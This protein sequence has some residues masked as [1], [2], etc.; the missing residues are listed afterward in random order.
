MSRKEYEMM[1]KLNAQLGGQF[2]SAFKSANSTLAKLQSEIQSLNKTQGDIS[3]YKK[4]QS[5][6]QQTKTKLDILQ[7]EYQ[8]L[9]EEYDQTGEG[10]TA[11][12][13]KMLKKKLAIEK[14]SAAVETHERKLNQLGDALHEAGVDTDNLT[15]ESQRL[16]EQQ[17]QLKHR[18]EEVA[19]E[20]DDSGEKAGKFGEDATGA[21]EGLKEALVSAGILQMIKAIGK[22]FIESAKESIMFESAI[23]GV[24]KTIDG[25]DEQLAA[26][27]SEIAQLATRI[28]ASTEEIAGVAEAAGQLGIAT[29]NVM[30]FSEVMI[31][32]GEATNLT[33]DE[34]ASA[35]AKFANIT[36]TA[37]EDY[38]RL[39]AV[40]VDM[41]NN[42]ATTEA[43]IVHMSTRLASAGTLA[44]LSEAEIMAL[45]TA[46]SSVGIE[47]EAGGTAMTQT[48]AAIEKAVVGGGDILDEYARISGMSAEK[49]ADAWEN[50][51]IEAIQAFIGGLGRLDE[52]GESATIVLDNLGLKGVRQSNMLKSLALASETL[53]KS[54]DVANTAWDENTALVEEAGKRYATTESKLAMV[55]NSYSNLKVAIGDVFTPVLKKLADLANKLLG[56][57]TEF[58]KNN[59]GV[60]KAI[61][62]V[63]IALGTFAG[64]LAA[65]TLVSKV[66]KAATVA[67]N[68]ALNSNPFMAIATAI[69]LVVT[70]LATYAIA[71]ADAEDASQQFTQTSQAEQRQIEELS[72][73]YDE[74]CKSYGETSEEAQLLGWKV[75][76]LTEHF[77]NNKQTIQEYIEE[78]DNF[79]SATHDMLDANMDAYEELDK[80][81]A[82]TYALVH[83]LEYL[84]NQSEITAESQAEMEAIIEAL[85]EQLPELKLNY[86]DVIS[87]MT[88]FGLTV[89]QIIKKEANR[90][91]YEKTQKFAAAALNAQTE[92]E[93]RLNEAIEQKAGSQERFNKAQAAYM[94]EYNKIPASKGYNDIDYANRV[95]GLEFSDVGKEYRAAQE[96]L[97]LYEGE[98][99]NAQAVFDEATA[100]YELYRGDLA[101][102]IGE[103]AEAGGEAEAAITATYESVEQLSVAYRDAY[104]AAYE[105]VSGQYSLWD[106][107]AEVV[108]TSASTINEG[109]ESQQTYWTD[110][111]NNLENLSARGEDIA[112]LNSM[113]AEFADGSA[114]SVNAIAGMA[115]ASDEELAE[116]VANWQKLKEEQDKVAGSLAEVRTDFSNQ[117]DLIKDDLADDISGMDLSDEAKESAKQ[118]IQGFIDGAKG[119]LPQVQQAYKEVGDTAARA[120]NGALDINSPSKVTDYS[121]QMSVKGFMLPA[122]EMKP[123]VRKAYHD[124]GE[125]GAEGISDATTNSPTP[126]LAEQSGG[127]S[128]VTMQISYT[129]TG[130]AGPELEG[131]LNESAQHLRQIVIDVMNERAVDESR[132]RY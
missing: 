51:P 23:T 54:V 15:G 124:L 44:G 36:G 117:M 24:Y 73:E 119:L 82:R 78:C 108:A 132:R 62:A 125:A 31:D 79:N 33:A 10:S 29:E 52:Q 16:S 49:F 74:A 18:Q 75:D 70:A 27:E 106:T 121:G 86:E 109:L 69:T 7:K 80:S 120:L 22:A 30:G 11:L 68:A 126:I 45:A 83:R 92:A 103:T 53:G 43:D 12:E 97:A 8:Q 1:L 48:L 14:A 72:A 58:V 105:S 95:G 26:I 111:N 9:Q 66:A 91:R 118:T 13:T 99:E 110:Y 38:G 87:G 127:A 131:Q 50:K 17:K 129:I 28:P 98:V 102:M 65:Y 20:F 89:D 37:A 21:I 6:L 39:G 40:V 67:L 25:T 63:T 55:K 96:E 60:V 84:A 100:D 116:M 5:A 3:A 112:G 34:A 47:A 76:E 90:D 107:A 104:T 115:S 61:S 2:G 42:F 123:E 35:F 113:I 19:D 93:Q 46:M 59:P 64:A 32:L 122:E 85:N 81:E 56:K 114:D 128:N 57:I 41:G 101:E 88:D 77:E 4:Q 130:S 94:E 71:A